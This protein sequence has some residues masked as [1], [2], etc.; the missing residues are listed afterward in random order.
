VRA[1][2]GRKILVTGGVRSG[3]SYFALELARGYPS[4]RIFLATAEAFDDGMRARIRAHQQERGPDFITLEAPQNLAEKIADLKT[5]PGIILVDCMT[6]W[7][8]NLI[9]DGAGDYSGMQEKVNAWIGF[10]QNFPGDMIFVTNEIG[11]GVM[12]EN[13]LSRQF[14]DELGALNRKLAEIADEVILM[15]AGIPQW[16]KGVR[17]NAD[18]ASKSTGR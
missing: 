16:M 2:L 9:Y 1:S 18:L 6:L 8:N 12:P 10:V 7:V 14:I 13:E 11:L 17:Q 15:V 5:E 4:P 3:K